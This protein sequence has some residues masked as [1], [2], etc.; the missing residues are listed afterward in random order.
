MNAIDT[1]IENASEITQ[2]IVIHLRQVIKT[3]CPAIEEQLKWKA[4]S[5]EK[6]GKIICSVMAFKG[7]VNFMITQ[8]KFLETPG[9]IFENIGDKSN[10]TGLKGIKSVNDLP[11]DDLLIETI[12]K[13]V[14]YSIAN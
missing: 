10:M 9:G 13:A 6:N 12:K 1:Y 5:F 2:P 4:P 8:G 14:E 11:N 7:H 3:A